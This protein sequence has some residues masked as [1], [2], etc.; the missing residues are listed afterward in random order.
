[1]TPALPLMR[2]ETFIEEHRRIHQRL[3]RLQKFAAP[4]SGF[5]SALSAL[6]ACM[7]EIDGLL[8]ELTEHFNREERVLRTVTVPFRPSEQQHRAEQILAEHAPLLRE[9]RALLESGR[10]VI[11]ELRAGRDAGP[12]AEALKAYLSASVQDLL[13]HEEREG[14]LL[15]GNS[16][17]PPKKK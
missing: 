12:L 8:P 16:P 11:D 7:D 9:L 14:I 6:L 15:L 3:V 5:P 4:D 2:D 17:T 10:R 13:E 1:M